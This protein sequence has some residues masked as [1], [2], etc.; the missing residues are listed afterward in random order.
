MEGEIIVV[1]GI[2]KNFRAPRGKGKD[3]QFEVLSDVNL[4]VAKDEFVS[5]IG[6]SGC[7]KTTLL[8]IVDGLIRPDKGRILIEGCPIDRPGSDRA[9]VF[10][11]FGLLPWKTVRE[12]V[13]FGLMLQ[14]VP[15]EVRLDKARRYVELV[16]LTGFGDYFPYQL[17][18]GMQQ[19]AGIARALCIDA[20]ILLMDEPLGAVDAQTREL[21]Q[22]EILRIWDREKR[23]VVF[24]THS[25]DEAVYLSDRIVIMAPR[26]GRVDEVLTV[27]LPRPRWDY[28]VRADRR[29]LDLRRFAW[30]RLKSFIRKTS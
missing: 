7:G 13:S 8:R 9:M 30:D 22:E 26:P 11:H 10:Q 2:S 24:V 23:T 21:M 3:A 29:Y 15:K 25:I 18:G 16:G 17:S 20:K 14:G 12:N 1:E 6:P 27:D 4:S 19:R 5:I 28:D